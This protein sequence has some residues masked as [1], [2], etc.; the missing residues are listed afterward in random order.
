[1]IRLGLCLLVLLVMA[2]STGSDFSLVPEPPASNPEQAPVALTTQAC[3]DVRDWTVV[4][5]RG[6][7]DVFSIVWC[8][9]GRTHSREFESSSVCYRQA[10][11]GRPLPRSCGY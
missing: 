6:V 5:I 11:I 2:C 9:S 3:A 10:E 7:T 4:R 1:M 8:Q